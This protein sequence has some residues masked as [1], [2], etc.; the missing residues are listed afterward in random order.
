MQIFGLKICLSVQKNAKCL[1]FANYSQIFGSKFAK[2][3]KKQLF[4]HTFLHMTFYAIRFNHISPDVG[5][6]LLVHIFLFACL[7]GA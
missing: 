2:F 4:L 3:E 5:L 7:D 1:N 6:H